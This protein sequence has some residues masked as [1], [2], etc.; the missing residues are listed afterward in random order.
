VALALAATAGTAAADSFVRLDRPVP[1]HEFYRAVACAAHP[2]G[3][4]RDPMG[5]WPAPGRRALTVALH[6][7]G[8]PRPDPRRAQVGQ[9]LDRAIAEIN[10]TGA[11]LHLVRHPD[12][13]AADIAL[14]HSDI[15]EGEPIVLPQA[16]LDGSAVMEGARVEIWW[17][18]R[19]RIYSAVIVIAGDLDA[20]DLRSVVLE[21][22]VQSLGFLTDLT[23]DAYAETSIFSED[24]NAVTRLTGQDAA[25]IRLH[26]PK[27]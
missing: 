1:D 18:G 7:Q 9:A 2:G 15:V 16:G 6:A 26:Y 5:A 14:W 17:D 24:S 22:M 12:G 4:C 13:T 3:D 25:A 20:A 27:E 11:D 8:D 23:G 19:F 21:E 10:R